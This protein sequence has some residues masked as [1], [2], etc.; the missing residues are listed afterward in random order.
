MARY[1]YILTNPAFPEWNKFGES[2]NAKE[3]AKQLSKSTGLPFS[4][5]VYA[6]LDLG[7]NNNINGF[8]KKIHK[9][10]EAIDGELRSVEKKDDGTIRH[11]EFF[12]IGKD[13]LFNILD[14]LK[15]LLGLPEESLVKI[16]TD[17]DRL[18]EKIATDAR[19]K[20]RDRTVFAKLGLKIGDVL[21]YIKRPEIKVIVQ[22]LENKVKYDGDLYGKGDDY[23]LTNLVKKIE[24]STGGVNGFASFGVN[25]SVTGNLKSLYELRLEMEEEGTYGNFES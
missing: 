12:N 18:E 15:S 2:N 20:Y 6:T 13:N 7:E 3:R 22:D 9:M 17:E 11:R 14:S 21:S 23:T 24:G 16:Q 25:D 19:N 8:D 5:K 10:I 1:I 4:F